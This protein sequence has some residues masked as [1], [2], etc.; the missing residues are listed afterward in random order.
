MIDMSGTCPTVRVKANLPDGFCLINE[1]DFDPDKHVLFASDAAEPAP[2]VAP[3]MIGIPAD[4]QSL[5]WKQRMALAE[6]LT[7]D[8]ALAPADGQK[9][10]DVADAV[11]AAEVARRAEG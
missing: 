6:K 1:S 2:I 3:P 8:R 7:G 4:W 5:H 10:V 9:P 11:I